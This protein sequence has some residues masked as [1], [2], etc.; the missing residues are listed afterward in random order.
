VR[1]EWGEEGRRKRNRSKDERLIRR[2]WKK[3]GRGE[4]RKLS[5]EQ[6]KRMKRG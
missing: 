6:G 5:A 3:Q 4:K 2:R 1:A